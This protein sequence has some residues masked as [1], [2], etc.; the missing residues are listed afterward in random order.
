[1][2]RPRF[3]LPLVAAACLS[4]L[5]DLTVPDDLLIAC[6]ANEDCPAGRFCRVGRCTTL[7]IGTEGE[8][9]T[10]DGRCEEGLSCVDSVCRAAGPA[11]FAWIE[12]FSGSG[13]QWADGFAAAPGGTSYL[14]GW[15][16]DTVDLGAGPV[17]AKGRREFYLVRR[18]ADGRPAWTKTFGGTDVLNLWDSAVAVTPDGS[19]LAFAA[20]GDGMLDFGGGPRG[21][22]VGTTIFLAEFDADGRHRWSKA[23][24]SGTGAE[25]RRVVIDPTGGGYLCG[26]FFGEIDFGLGEIQAGGWGAPYLARFASDGTFRWVRQFG[27][28][29]EDWDG[30]LVLDASARSVLLGTVEKTVTVG[31]TTITN[32]GADLFLAGFDLQGNASFVK[33]LR[34]TAGGPAALAMAPGGDLLVATDYSDRFDGQWASSHVL[35][36]ARF[37]PAGTRRWMRTFP[38]GASWFDSVRAAP[39]GRIVLAG[40]LAGSATFGTTTLTSLGDADAL[41]VVLDPEGQS[42]YAASWGAAGNQWLSAATFDDAGAVLFAGAYENAVNF[43][44]GRMLTETRT[45]F[46]ARLVLP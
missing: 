26:K 9:C 44:T 25:T 36:V 4:C 28:D 46:T 24:G 43:G 14:T 41:L 8:A 37:D 40:G 18:G 27:S 42:L 34:R 30:R 29:E 17:K 15:F 10:D 22:D 45:A 1:M 16:K 35:A 7:Y 38:T 20:W 32:S 11:G 3:G 39:D 19:R 5:G 6:D 21:I 13:E 33:V 2:R 12:P 31:T 23:I